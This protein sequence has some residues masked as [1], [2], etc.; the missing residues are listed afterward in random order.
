[1]INDTH[2]DFSIKLDRLNNLG[3]VLKQLA[4]LKILPLW[5]DYNSESEPS[6]SIRFDSL[7]F[8]A[9]DQDVIKVED[10]TA[11]TYR[12]KY[13]GVDLYASICKPAPQPETVKL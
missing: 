9:G 3:N 5:I 11:I 8:L 13:M 7:S 2:N 1:M 6:I 4:M 12:F 10:T